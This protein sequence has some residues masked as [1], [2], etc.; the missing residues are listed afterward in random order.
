MVVILLIDNF[1]S[2]V[3]NLA[4]YVVESGASVKVV[5]NN[6]IT[7][8]EIRALK[9]DGIILSPGP[10]SP[11]EAGICL[12]VV[13]ELHKEF[14]ILGV[15]LGHQ[16]IGQ[17]FGGDVVRAIKPMHGKTEIIEHSGV[18][19]LADIASPTT[20]TR[21]HS[22]VV[23]MTNVKDLNVTSVTNK[24][25]VMAIE[26]I[27][28]PVYGVQFHPEAVL[29]EQGRAMIKNFLDICNKS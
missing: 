11:N 8:D 25:E 16:A 13:H 3:Y 22:L 24:G 1:D 23:D 29:T 21:Y 17:A 2:F 28:L 7:I 12:S 20:V 5:R 18:G 26:H 10:K 9:P 15:C 4:R 6:A 27:R 19:V 14:P